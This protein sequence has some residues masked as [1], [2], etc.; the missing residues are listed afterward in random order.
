MTRLGIDFGTTRTIVALADR[1]NYPVAQ[2]LDPDGNAHSFVPTLVACL[3]DGTLLC[4]HAAQARPELPLLRSFKRLLADPHLAMD[5]PVTIGKHTFLLLDVLTAFFTSLRMALAASTLAAHLDADQPLEAVVAV[6]ARAFGMQRK[7]TLEAFRRA[8]FKITA[9]FNEPSAA[10]FEFTHARPTSMTSQ[11]TRV[12]VYDFGG[13]TFDASLVAIDGKDHE[14]IATA[15]DNHLGGDDVDMVL[16]EMALKEAGKHRK[17]LSPTDFDDLLM[18][19]RTAKENL[20]PQSRRIVLDVAGEVVA[21]PVAEFYDSLTS[22]VDRTITAMAPLLPS[23]GAQ[24]LKDEDVAGIYVVGGSSSL[25]LVPRAL[26]ERFGRRVLRSPLPAGSVAVGLA[27]AADDVGYDLS[28]QLSRSFGVFREGDAG[29]QTTFDAIVG[30][31]EALPSS[32]VRTLTRRYHA[33]HNIGV[34]RFV[35]ARELDEHGLP[36]GDVAPFACVTHPFAP[37]LEQVEDLAGYPVL[38][39]ESWQEIEERYELD[40]A[41]MISVTIRNLGTGHERAYRLA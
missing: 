41:G 17:D 10:G 25:P 9:L 23:T 19:C 11:R 36:V 15:G 27:I 26:R 21:L 40:A 34:F 14:V 5:T 2:F 22:I 13:G 4:G 28:D 32:G 35:E 18:Q 30:A 6:P 31:H 3:P 33:A 38:R 8:G 16:L 37:E 39:D 12:I 20:V 29:T 24:A 1:G 7:M